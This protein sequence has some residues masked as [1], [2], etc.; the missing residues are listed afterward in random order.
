[1]VLVLEENDWNVVDIFGAQYQ[2]SGFLIRRLSCIDPGVR[3]TVASLIV[4]KNA[5][6]DLERFC[7]GFNRSAG[8]QN[9]CGIDA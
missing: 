9:P 1:M 6:C 8:L 2:G 7:R 5:R 3:V 4:Q